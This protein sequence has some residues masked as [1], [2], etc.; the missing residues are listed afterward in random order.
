MF[1]DNWFQIFE[2]VGDGTTRIKIDAGSGD[3]GLVGGME[4]NDLMEDAI[5]DDGELRTVLSA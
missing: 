2:G 1:P 4:L 3:D 5:N